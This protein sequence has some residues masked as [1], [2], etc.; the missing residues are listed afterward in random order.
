MNKIDIQMK[1]NENAIKNL[2]GDGRTNQT[3]KDNADNILSLSNRVSFHINATASTPNTYIAT[4]NLVD[5]YF[6][7]MLILLSVTETNTASSTLNIN[8]LGTKTL[9]KINDDGDIDNI[10]PNGLKENKIYLFRYNGSV[11]ILVNSSSSE[12]IYYNNENS[13]LQSDNIQDAIDE[14]DDKTEILSGIKISVGTT[15]PTGTI[16]WLDTTPES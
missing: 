1:T 2:A 14:I 9:A 5:N 15:E 7:N 16:F 8:G 3:V 11:F 4:N 12:D 10:L 13:E 6:N